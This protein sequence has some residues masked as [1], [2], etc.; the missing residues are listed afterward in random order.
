MNIFATIEPIN[1]FTFKK[2][3]YYSVLFENE[4]INE[5]LDFLNRMEDDKSI[6]DELEKLF[7][8]LEEIGDKY[9]AQERFFRPEKMAQ[10]LPSPSGISNN[11]LKINFKK[12]LRLYC[13]R[14]ND[15]VVFLF[16]GG[17]KTKGIKLAQD[18]PIVAPHF[19][20][21]NIIAQAIEKL[22]QAGD[23]QWNEN[24]T[25]ILYDNDLELEI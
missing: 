5:F 11:V 4:N 20:K 7:V 1:S 24:C 23:I 16:N 2:V 17:V 6:D 19:N 9:G 12:N 22:F 10:A 15:H 3:K 14:L 13:L 18:C 21:A 8:C 25:D